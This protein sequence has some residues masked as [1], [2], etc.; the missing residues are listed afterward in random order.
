M[1]TGE[2]PPQVP[3]TCPD[4]RKATVPK[5]KVKYCKALFLEPLG[6]K[7]GDRLVPWNAKAVESGR[8]ING[9]FSSQSVQWSYTVM[10]RA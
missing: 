8:K 10:D 2:L 5:N 3:L 1:L 9:K 7:V 6:A 4:G